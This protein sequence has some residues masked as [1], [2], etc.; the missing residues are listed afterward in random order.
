MKVAFLFVEKDPNYD[1]ALKILQQLPVQSIGGETYIQVGLWMFDDFVERHFRNIS[2]DI[3]KRITLIAQL[4]FSF[5]QGNLYKI[6]EPAQENFTKLASER[7]YVVLFDSIKPKLALYLHE[8]LSRFEE[9]LGFTQVLSYLTEHYNIFNYFRHLFKIEQ[10]KIFILFSEFQHDEW[11]ANE[12]LEWIKIHYSS[13]VDYPLLSIEKKDIGERFSVIDEH[14]IFPKEIEDG[15]KF[16]QDEWGTHCEQIIYKLHESVPEA[17][18]ELVSATRILSKAR[19]SSSECAQIAV[20][21]RRCLDKIADFLVPE[22]SKSEE[23]Q[24]NQNGIAGV[25]K[26]K[27]AKYIKEKLSQNEYYGEYLE[28]ELDELVNKVVKIYNIS[29][30]GV[31]NDWF[32]YQAFS[33]LS[34]RVILL[35][36]DL[37]M[38]QNIVRP[39]TIYSSALL[40]I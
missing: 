8:R 26:V 23:K 16:F 25:S 36:N 29:N 18:E 31:H 35:I 34:L 9:Y 6:K 11:L 30:K 2:S 40:N 1:L 20:N 39:T 3:E 5:G 4:I 33:I 14:E 13:L 17:L 12:I 37:L 28:S 15:I 22:L 7:V 38:P 19:C 27:L 21:L 32:Y 24:F 10:G